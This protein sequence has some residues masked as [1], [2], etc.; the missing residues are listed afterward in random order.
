MKK[1]LFLTVLLSSFRITNAQCWKSVST[2]LNQCIAVKTNGTLWGWGYNV[3]GELGDGT[4]INKNYPVQIN[5]DTDWQ[6]AF[7]GISHSLALKKDSSLWAWGGN[8]SGELGDGSTSSSNI[9]KKI[10]ADR[11]W[12]AISAGGAHSLAIKSDG[13]LWAWGY[14][15]YGELGIGD[16]GNLGTYN[17]IT[18]PVQVGTDNNWLIISASQFC[19]YAI[20]KDGSLWAWGND[21][22][23]TLGLGDTVYG[24]ISSPMQIGTDTNWKYVSA[25]ANHGLAIKTDGT[26]WAWGYN[27]DGELGDNTNINKEVPVQIGADNNWI[28]T[29][30]SDFS[31]YAIKNDGTLWV[32]GA[33]EVG[34]LGDGT[35][36]NKNTPAKIS[37]NTSW[38]LIS[39]GGQ[40]AV[41]LKSD[42]TLWSW[43]Y[44]D[45]GQLGLGI[46]DDHINVPTEIICSGTL[47]IKLK[48]F[49]AQKQHE[50]TLLTWQTATEQNNKEYQIER[51]G[52]G[53]TFKEIASTQS[54]NSVSGSR[55]SYVDTHPLS[56][57]NYYRLKSMDIDGKFSYSNIDKVT[58][59]L[60]ANN[61]I[62]YP[63]PAKDIL[64]VQSNFKGERL[65]ITLTDLAG[66]KILQTI[67]QNNQLIE[68]PIFDL[69]AGFYLL[70]IN[71]GISSVSKKIIKE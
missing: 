55:Y 11:N 6:V 68:I 58:F 21:D 53:N 15:G 56:G 14:D 19:S 18:S 5:G 35:Y 46:I 37:S 63:N 51:S 17:Y 23:K 33:N 32:Y 64:T 29:S 54:K 44:N 16:L 65:N 3:D 48:S 34:Q 61:V 12:I 66:R 69:R 31:S 26:L 62:V 57:N 52:D 25:G 20:K 9:P 39:G 27:Y 41:A 8:S 30:A 59:N 10:G 50:T 71:D 2:S 40:Q 36:I 70:K 42:S 67:K 24:I 47:P 22:S 28:S 1:I 45:F 49:I 38:L 60:N 43:G 7:T 4:N 13:T